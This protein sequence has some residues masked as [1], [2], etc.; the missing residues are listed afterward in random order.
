VF[1]LGAWEPAALA[2]ALEAG[3]E[4]PLSAQAPSER[5]PQI[6]ELRLRLELPER[7]FPRAGERLAAYLTLEHAPATARRAGQDLVLEPGARA[8]KRKV[9]LKGIVRPGAQGAVAELTVGPRFRLRRYLEL[10]PEPEAWRRALVEV[11]G[12]P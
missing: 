2:A 6:A 9:L 12:W 8:L 3:P 7:F 10:F 4:G 1:A 11:L 5:P